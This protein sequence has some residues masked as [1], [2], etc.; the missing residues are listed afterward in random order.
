MDRKEIEENLRKKIVVG[1]KHH[2]GNA[3]GSDYCEQEFHLNC[4]PD[5][6]IIDGIYYDKKFM[7]NKRRI[8]DLLHQIL[9]DGSHLRQDEVGEFSKD[10][11][12]YDYLDS[13]ASIILDEIGE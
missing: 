4:K 2:C 9:V 10:N 8:I 12:W 3:Y 5:D 13:E 11:E 7:K 1:V 6:L